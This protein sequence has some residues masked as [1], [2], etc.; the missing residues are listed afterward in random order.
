MAAAKKKA[1]KV[2]SDKKTAKTTKKVVKKVVKKPGKK[3]MTELVYPIVIAPGQQVIQQF[4]LTPRKPTATAPGNWQFVAQGTTADISSLDIQFSENS[5]FV[6][7]QFERAV[8]I[9]SMKQDPMMNGTWRFALSGVVADTADADPSNDIVV[10]VI[11]SG[12]TMIAYIHA[13]VDPVDPDAPTDEEIGFRFVASYSDNTTGAV[14][15]F[16]SKDPVVKITR[17]R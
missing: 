8:L 10:E 6:Q 7:S 17:P 4:D 16:E 11:D 9:I 13:P 14:S 2:D 12:L 1:I 3:L 5:T 15:I